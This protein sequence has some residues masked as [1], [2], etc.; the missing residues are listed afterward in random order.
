MK[1]MTTIK[2]RKAVLPVAGMGTRF[3]P[4]TKVVP[5]ELLPIV[6]KPVIQYLVEEAVASGAEEII[7][8]ISHQKELIRQYFTHHPE[9]EELLFKKGKHA[10]LEAIKPI[11]KMARFTFVYQDEALGD[12]HAILQAEKAVGNEPFL[13]LFGDD[14]VKGEV[15]AARQLI[16]QFRGES[17]IA[18]ENV[19]RN[20]TK[21]YGIIKP[22]QR[23]G[24]KVEVLGL[25]EKPEPKVAPSTLGI[26][27]KY[28]C[29]PEIFG[30]L[31]KAKRGKDGEIR[32]IDGF[33]KLMKTQKIWAVEIEG[34]RFDTG[35]PEG[36]AAAIR[37]YL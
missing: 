25:V 14:I 8:V 37:A 1:I 20:K 5:K 7:F 29:P 9:L 22:G 10:L 33:I 23:L 31:K 12:G 18:V 28:V 17:V 35:N 4:I 26:I 16:N 2:I 13:I 34:E 32:L 6:D 19:P 15:P 36:L 21:L 24:G 30:A 27:G 3:L 11:H